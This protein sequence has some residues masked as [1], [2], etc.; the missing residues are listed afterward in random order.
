MKQ[1]I[2]KI[3]P[4]SAID[5]II[6]VKNNYLNSYS[7][8]SFS[9][10]G[11][12]LILSRIFDKVDK[13]FYVDVGAYHPIRFSNTYLFYKKGWH[14]I[15][16][17]AMPNSMKLFN[18]IRKKDINLEIPISDEEV[19][20]EYHIFN[21]QAMNTFSKAIAN[22]RNKSTSKFRVIKVIKIK[23]SKLSD[24]FDKYIDKNQKIDFMNIDV[25]GFEL[26][27]LKSNNWEK[28]LPKVILV[29][30]LNSN[31]RDLVD[32]KITLFLEGIGY[33]LYAKCAHTAFY[34]LDQVN[35]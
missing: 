25:E 31:L 12:D 29:E 16:I 13:G 23:P 10:E 32:D 33:I 22:E 35:K 1:I 30:I 6:N 5:I 28:Y 24:I 26:K 17:D 14:G 19:F 7:L 18:R 8:K 27:V 20:L 21:E 3:L 15:N 4:K 2:K 11:E 9:Q 34:K